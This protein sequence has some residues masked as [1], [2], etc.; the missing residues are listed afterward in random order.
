MNLGGAINSGTGWEDNA[1]IGAMISNIGDQ[2]HG[3]LVIE[4]NADINLN[5]NSQL[6][7]SQVEINGGTIDFAGNALATH[8]ARET[9]GSS[10][11]SSFIRAFDSSGY[12][13]KLKNALN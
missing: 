8:S 9:S 2:T 1:M 4:G 11:G 13:H 6:Y 12:Y 3:H 7:G 5:A 10:A